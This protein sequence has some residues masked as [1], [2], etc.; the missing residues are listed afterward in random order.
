[1][2]KWN[3]LWTDLA[4]K[5]ESKRTR[6]SFRDT[7]ELKKK[8]KGLK[9]DYDRLHRLSTNQ[10]WPVFRIL[11]LGSGSD[12]YE[13]ITCYCRNYFHCNSR[14]Q[15]TASW[16]KYQSFGIIFNEIFL[17]LTWNFE[18]FELC[19]LAFIARRQGIWI[20]KTDI[21]VPYFNYLGLRI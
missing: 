11:Q 15:S 14:Y 2:L 21:G 16:Q 12:L 6:I 1:L 13:Q 9:Q 10:V 8:A 18:F 17:N 7:N 19:Q 3:Y 5:V 4:V 20:I